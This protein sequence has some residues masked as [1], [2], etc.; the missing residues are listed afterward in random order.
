MVSSVPKCN[1]FYNSKSTEE[2]RGQICNRLTCLR[3]ALSCTIFYIFTL[4]MTSLYKYAYFL[5]WKG[6]WVMDNPLSAS[7]DYYL[8]SC[9]ENLDREL[10]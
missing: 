4:H 5:N 10:S 3:I 1:P 6:Y 7:T 2:P 8:F 9:F